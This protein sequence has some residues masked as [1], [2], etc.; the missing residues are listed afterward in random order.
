MAVKIPGVPAFRLNSPWW[1]N[2]IMGIIIGLTA[3]LYQALNLL[4]AGGGR[5]NS[6]QTV[7]VVNATLCA[8]YFFSSNLGGSVLNTIGPAITAILG[9]IGF[10]LY[11]GGLW[12]FDQTGH[13][14]FAIFGGVAIGISAGLVFVTMGS[15]AMSYSE[16]EE[17]GSFIA[18]S[19]NLQAVGCAVGGIIPLIINRDSTEAAGVPV[20]VYVIIIVMMGCG[21][22]LALTLRHPSKVIRDDGTQVAVLHARGFL[23]ELKAN[24]EIFKDWRLLIMIP[25]FLPSECFL[26][27]SGSVNAYHNDLRTRCLLSFC[28]VVVQIPCGYGLQ[29]ILDHKTWT[30]RKRAFVGLAAVGIPLMGAWIWEIVRVRNYDRSNPPTDPMDWTDGKFPAI[31]IL[32]VLT[33]C[34]SI[35]M[36]YIILYYLSCLTNSPVKAA[37]YAGVYRGFL[38]GGE[39][40]IFGLDSI[41][42]PYIKEAGVLFTFYATGILIFIYLAATQITQT[43]YFTGE[44]GVVIP[45]HVVEEHQHELHDVKGADLD[46]EG[47]IIVATKGE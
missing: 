41:A 18:I 8:V 40:I 31:F 24:L 35:L 32:F 28:A 7:Q 9:I 2:F 21:C 10:A 30:R 46:P 26:V 37:N 43:E 42:I 19:V 39:A 45:K 3:G 6:F 5:P 34:S 15:I 38:A 47:N 16:E 36:Q 23:Q 33:W 44:E 17:R 29:K 11:V 12:Y 27:Y 22:L 13:E 25:A 4:G 1:Q 14:W 20:A